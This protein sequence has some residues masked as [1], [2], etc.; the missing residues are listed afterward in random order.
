MRDIG[1][2]SVIGTLL[3]VIFFQNLYFS[4]SEFLYGDSINFQANVIQADSLEEESIFVV[5]DIFL[6]RNVETLTNIS[7]ELYSYQYLF[8]YINNSKVSI[9]NFESSVPE[10]HVKTPNL[11]YKFSV[12]DSAV[13]TLGDVG[14]NVLSLANNHSFDY[15]I[16]GY[17]NT[18][19]ICAE[20]NISCVGSPINLATSSV[21]FKEVGDKTVSIIFLYGIGIEYSINDLKSVTHFAKNNSDIQIAYIHWGDEYVDIHNNKQ[22]Q[23]AYNLIDLGVDLI[24][25]HHPHVVQ[26]IGLYKN[27]LIVYSLGNFIF[28]QYFNNKV[29]EGLALDVQITETELTYSL[30]PVES[31]TLRSSP[32][33]MGEEQKDIFL[34]DLAKRSDEKLYNEIKS[35]I[36]KTKY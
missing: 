9:G 10:E 29:Q 4:Y 14:F 33:F 13:G 31:L 15:G 2:S 8:D 1:V 26:D 24:V 22:E 30:L 5:G 21:I 25:G 7:G 20:N 28:D 17:E 6:G 34:N 32:K 35:G 18:K 12:K 23:L 11:S 36:I 16:D 27:R 19:K 3:G